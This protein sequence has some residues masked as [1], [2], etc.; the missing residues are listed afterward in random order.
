MKTR[1]PRSASE[2]RSSWVRWWVG[3]SSAQSAA[4]TSTPGSSSPVTWESVPVTTSGT[5]TTFWT[6]WMTAPTSATSAARRSTEPRRL[7]K[8]TWL[9]ATLKT[10]YASG[11]YRQSTSS[12]SEISINR[13]SLLAI[14]RDLTPKISLSSIY[15]RVSRRTTSNSDLIILK[16]GSRRCNFS[17]W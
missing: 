11:A 6:S 4:P 14:L 5:T 7:W 13:E 3:T 2:T 17:R 9:N 15:P 16:L 8:T 10:I 1:S 12:R